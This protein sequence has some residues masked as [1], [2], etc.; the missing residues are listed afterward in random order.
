MSANP[1]IRANELKLESEKQESQTTLRAAGRI[2]SDTCV[3]LEKTLRE[4]IPGSK[5]LVLDL[6]N[7]NYIDSSGLGALV[8]AYMHARRANCDL[9]IANP[10]QQIKDLFST[11]KLAA[12]F[13]GRHE[14]LGLTPD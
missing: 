7:V 8:S 11:S 9:E 1:G 10:R 5:R 4:L 2:N 13:E 6:T 14:W 3:V 12:V